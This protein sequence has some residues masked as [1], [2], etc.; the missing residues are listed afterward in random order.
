MIENVRELSFASSEVKCPVIKMHIQ[1]FIKYLFS[2]YLTFN[3]RI[4][5]SKIQVQ[6]LEFEIRVSKV[7]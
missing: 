2:I 7:K 4:L 6:I 3:T 5:N 1:D